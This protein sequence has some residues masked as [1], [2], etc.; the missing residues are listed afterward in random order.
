MI[1][2][3]ESFGRFITILQTFKGEVNERTHLLVDPVSNS[4]A[5][6]RTNSEDYINDY[7]NSLPKRD[8]QTALS[9]IISETA[10]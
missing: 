8:E 7:P 2:N 4:P 6:R 9:R 10:T 5:V 1:S 3:S